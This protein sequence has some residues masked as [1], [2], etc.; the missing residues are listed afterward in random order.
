MA[1]AYPLPEKIMTEQK[2]NANQPSAWPRTMAKAS[3]VAFVVVLGSVM[4]PGSAQ[5]TK[6]IIEIAAVIFASAGICMGIASL[7]GIAKYGIKKILA[8]ALVG[9]ITNSLFMCIFVT[10]VLRAYNAAK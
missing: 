8:P 1:A 9:I 10:N 5:M 7:F 6:V 4:F 2:E 3:W